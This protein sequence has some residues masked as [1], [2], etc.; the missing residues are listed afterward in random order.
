MDLFQASCLPP[1]G[2]AK[3]VQNGSRQFCDSL[4]YHF[5]GKQLT[6]AAKTVAKHVL[7]YRQLYEQ[8]RMKKTTSDEMALALVSM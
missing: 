2:P 8:L 1:F 4:S 3:A 6:V 7:H 5:N